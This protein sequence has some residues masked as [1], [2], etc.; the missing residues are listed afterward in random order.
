M[1]ICTVTI[2][3]AYNRLIVFSLSSVP[4]LTSLSFTFHHWCAQLSFFHLIR[5]ACSS[6]R[7]PPRSKPSPSP[8]R[9][10]R[11]SHRTSPST[12]PIHFVGVRILRFW[13]DL[14]GEHGVVFVGIYFGE[15]WRRL[16]S[17]FAVT[18]EEDQPSE[19]NE[20]TRRWTTWWIAWWTSA[21]SELKSD[22]LCGGGL[23][24]W[25]GESCSE[26]DGFRSFQIGY[27]REKWWGRE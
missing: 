23:G 17:N 19:P 20:V 8:T 27:V 5:L 9:S 18:A 12:T 24:P 1:Q 13:S 15:S 4:C 22:G 6:F 14:V 16:R 10:S 26:G 25:E 3:C 11:P 2:A 21:L 7:R